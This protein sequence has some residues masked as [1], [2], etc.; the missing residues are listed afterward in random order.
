MRK[1]LSLCDSKARFAKRAVLFGIFLVALFLG[2]LSPIFL[3]AQDLVWETEGVV[4][5]DPTIRNVEVIPLPAQAGL[6]DTQYRMFFD[7]GGEI[8][9]ALSSDGRSFT[10]EDGVRV[11][12]TMPAIVKLPDG[13]W[14]IYFASPSGETSPAEGGASF[15]ANIIKSAVSTDGL[16][17]TIEE[18]TRLLPGGEFDPDNIV[19]PSVIS[20]PEGG[21]R[22]YYDGEVRRSEQD[23]TRRILSATSSDGVTWTKDP[24]VRINVGEGPLYADLVWGA[25]A[26]YYALTQTYQLYFSAS[27]R[28]ATEPNE[29][30]TFPSGSAIYSATSQDG[31][32]FTV[33][34][35]PELAL[36]EESGEPFVLN[37]PETKRM[38][39][40][41][42]G[43]GIY[44][45]VLKEPRP[46][47]REK[48]LGNKL[49]DLW[50][51]MLA[52]PQEINLQLPQNLELYIVPTILLVIGL[53]AV[54]Y[55][56]RARL[57]R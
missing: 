57:R 8:K 53:G 1:A 19:H 32:L 11:P 5:S 26:E 2:K 25:H 23:F 41:V 14:R 7:Q 13:S 50:E 3:C 43:S 49:K 29:G 55:L 37:F 45:A 35:E 33:S 4:F 30:G 10:I 44:S 56:W 22:M 40:W 6:L 36:A 18:G 24:G 20:R 12:G 16:S 34:P 48:G 21:Y 27:R 9:S 52:L 39:Y 46:L 28:N 54:I 47:S 17:W 38:Y 51:K 31:L 42:N 15:A